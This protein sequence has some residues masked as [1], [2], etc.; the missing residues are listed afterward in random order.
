MSQAV[1]QDPSRTSSGR[2]ISDS[3][4]TAAKAS[5]GFDALTSS[6]SQKSKPVSAVQT[7]SGSR[8]ISDN[9]DAAFASKAAQPLRNPQA[10]SMAPVG[11]K[12]GSKSISDRSARSISDQTADFATALDMSILA[13]TTA[14]FGGGCDTG[15]CDTGCE[16]GGCDSGC[17][18]G[19]RSK[20]KGILASLGGSGRKNSGKMWA[21]GEFL[22]W[23]TNG[24]SSPALVTTSAQGV[25]PTLGS[26]GV[27]T[28]FGGNNGIDQGIIPG[29]RAE[30]GMWLDD[31]QKFGVSGRVL[32]FDDNEDYSLASDGSTSIGIPFFNANSGVLAEDAYLVAFTTAANAPVSTGNVYARSDLDLI[33]AE[34]SM[35]MLLAGTGSNRVDFL[36]GYTY[37]RIKSSLTLNTTSTNLFTGDLIQD[38]TVFDTN[39]LFE[40][41]NEFHGAHLGVLSNVTRKGLTLST[42]AKVSFG[43]MRQ[44]G[45]ISGFTTESFGG[46]SSTTAGGVFSQPSNIGTFTTTDNF[47]FIPELGI[48]LG[49]DVNQNLRATL[50]YTFMYYSSVALA[51]DQIDRTVDLTGGVARPSANFIDS[52]LWTQGI[53][54][55]MTYSF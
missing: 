49:Y 2:R 54:F 15:S 25:L 48:K 26:T 5:T 13:P 8:S 12:K 21:T 35:R 39:D 32:G 45:S 3:A 55:G 42:L 43:N 52:S 33:G 28:A 51:G 46:A 53:D 24:S 19:G 10:G 20:G 1:A 37:T 36:A 7:A 16:S 11:F 4:S 23:F 22:L 6:R 38:G 31:C 40:T 17:D 27:N 30:A 47:A 14:S 29:F 50:G 41:S 34:G 44:N 9:G 18:S